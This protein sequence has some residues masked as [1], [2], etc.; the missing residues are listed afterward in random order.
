ML[1]LSCGETVCYVGFIFQIVK[2]INVSEL[3]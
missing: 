2:V 3:A 1:F